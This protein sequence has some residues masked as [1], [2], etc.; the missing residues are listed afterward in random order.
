MILALYWGF[1]KVEVCAV[2]V[3]SRTHRKDEGLCY[4]RVMVTSLLGDPSA[5]SVH[6]FGAVCVVF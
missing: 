1:Q 6:F 3:F 5:A 2:L 4:V